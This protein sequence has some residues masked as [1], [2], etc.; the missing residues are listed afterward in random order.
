MP[1]NARQ[2]GVAGGGIALPLEVDGFH[3]N[4]ATLSFLTRRQ[5]SIG[6]RSVL[7]DVYGVYSTFGLPIGATGFWSINVVNLS[8][9]T[10]DEI[11]NLGRNT[12]RIWRNND[13]SG[14][15]SWGKVILK[16]LGVGISLKGMYNN[17]STSDSRFAADGLAF[18]AGVQYRWLKGRLIAGAVVKNIGFVRESYTG[19]PR[20]YATPSVVG[21]GISFIPRYLSSVRLMCD[22]DKLKN[23][24]ATFRPALELLFMDES[25]RVRA[26][27]PFSERDL[28]EGLN[29]LRGNPTDGYQK[30]N[31]N[32]LAIGGGIKTDIRKLEAMA[33]IAIQFKRD[34]SPSFFVSLTGAY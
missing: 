16:N 26:G 28:T 14:S 4:P 1:Y 25:I 2:A 7:L 10:L 9:G 19:T 12:G 32:T 18:D 24:Y 29:N 15:I 31:F 8:H 30:T 33:D 22:V 21:A 20:E 17:I 27:Y 13:F 5:G 34:A 3:A 23:D 6:Y 11:D